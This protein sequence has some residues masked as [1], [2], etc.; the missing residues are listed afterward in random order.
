MLLVADSGSSKTDWKLLLPN[1]STQN[2]QTVGIN[3]IFST[4]KDIFR[5][6]SHQNQ[7][8]LYTSQIKEVFFFGAG[9]NS[10]D[11]RE[12]VSNALS[13]KFVNAFI[14]VET[15]LAGAAYATCGKIPGLNCIIGTES[16]LSFFDGTDVNEINTGLG[17]IL[18][19]EG[20]GTYFGKKLITDFLYQKMPQNLATLFQKAYKIN[21]ETIIKNIYQKPLPNYYLA[22]FSLFM[23]AFEDNL[24]IQNIL[25]NG[26][27]KYVLNN[28]VNY[29][30]YKQYP[31]HF[32]GS[33]AFNFKD[34]LLQVCKNHEVNVGRILEKPI[35]ALFEFIKM[36]E[37][38]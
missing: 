16:N 17:Y 20:S 33:I 11:R 23:S 19:D 15:D 32:V 6:L 13:S 29:Q 34:M 30:K 36:R 1:G 21:K 3:P 24:Y 12:F 35:E 38:Y 18:G 8:S 7:F 22:S 14:S 10:P 25:L 2:F 4:E 31:T 26:F 5:I 9:C 37:A 28:I 27:D